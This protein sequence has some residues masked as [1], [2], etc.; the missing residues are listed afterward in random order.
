MMKLYKIKKLPVSPLAVALTLLFASPAAFAQDSGFYGGLNIGKSLG[1]I[2]SD[3][4]SK[5]L[6]PR[7]FAFTTLDLS[8]RD[9]AWKVLAGY[10]FN[11]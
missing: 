4:L 6:Q 8:D 10:D 11:R 9:T 3:S 2:A 1:N 7:G 5:T